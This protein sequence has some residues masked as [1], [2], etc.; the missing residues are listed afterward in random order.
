MRNSQLGTDL[1]YLDLA[2]GKLHQGELFWASVSLAARRALL[3]ELHARTAANAE[4]WV[5]AA[6]EL[7]GLDQHSP[8]AGEEWLSGP[9]AL[10]T[11]I[12]ALAESIAKL[13]SGRS[14]LDGIHLGAAPGGRVAVEVMPHGIFDSLLLNGY[15]AEVWLQPGVDAAAARRAAGLAQR[16]PEI[17]GG[18]GLVLGAGN[19]A[20]IAPLDVLYEIFAHNRVVMLKLNPIMDRMLPVLSEI[21]APLI[22]RDIV[23]I[24][25]GGAEVGTFL[26]HHDLISHVHMTGSSATHDAIVFG[27]GVEGQQR[28]LDGVPLLTKPISSELGGVSPTVIFPGKWSKADLRFQAEHV[29][30]QRLHNGGYNCIAAQAVVLSADWPQKQQFLA[31]LRNALTDGPAR[32]DYYP[33]SRQRVQSAVDSSPDAE[34]LG[35]DRGRVLICGIDAQGKHPL[36]TTEYFAPVLGVVELPGSGADFAAAA[37]DFVNN[38]LVGTLGA[39]LIAHPATIRDL[40]EVFNTTIERLRY[41]TIAINAW[42]GLGYLTAR[43]TWGA[44]PG[45]TLDD[46]QSGIGVVHNALLIDRTERTVVRG[47]FRPIRRALLS[48]RPT[49]SP[50]PPWFVSNKTAQV[51]ARRLSGFAAGPAWSKLPAIFISALRG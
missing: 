1:A 9:Y 51:T 23:R 32:P 18:I 29:A 7:K 21:F 13:E 41:G 38:Q 48:S 36:T 42:T 44:F 40:G 30:T 27:V 47:P 10:L 15:S 24:T 45:H 17:T 3:Q 14:P 26:A 19:I 34:L 33:G 35:P 22:D 2:L 11:S 6:L 8:L 31:E 50:K 25:T 37:V 49:I 4:A 43:A 39:N 20:S 5:Q 16:A 12:G 28:K 46:V